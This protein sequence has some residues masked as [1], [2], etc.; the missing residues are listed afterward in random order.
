MPL[1][2]IELISFFMATELLR[3]FHQPPEKL[4]WLSG[5]SA[6]FGE[7]P[8][9][10]PRDFPVGNYGTW[11]KTSLGDNLLTQEGGLFDTAT[12]QLVPGERPTYTT[13]PSTERARADRA[14]A[15]VGV[16]NACNNNNSRYS[17]DLL[18][19]GSEQVHAR[20]LEELQNGSYAALIPFAVEPNTIGPAIQYAAGRIPEDNV[21][22]VDAGVDPSSTQAAQRASETTGVNVVNQQEVL[23]CIDWRALKD[24]GILPPHLLT[25]PKGNKGLTIYAGLLALEAAGKLDKTVML[26]DSDILN[27]GQRG[28]E[29]QGSYRE[30]YSPL[31]YLVL[32]YVYPLSDIPANAVMALR[33]GQG[34]YNEPLI[35]TANSIVNGNFSEHVR[36]LA[37]AYATLGWPI[38]GERAIRGNLLRAMPLPTGIFG[39][40]SHINVAL[41]SKDVQTGHKGV[42]QV[43]IPNQKRENRPSPRDREYSIVFGASTYLERLLAFIEQVGRDPLEWTLNDTAAFNQLYGGRLD[44]QFVPNRYEQQPNAPIYLASDF[45]LPSMVQLHQLG[46]VDWDRMQNAIVKGRK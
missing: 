39:L 14:L 7:H 19:P 40:E 2:E 13:T 24:L 32:P 23:A 41:S 22:T 38:T 1:R 45:V 43:A 4:P 12:P 36:A 9:F 37:L 46:V 28:N 6:F 42:M 29:H 15:H 33:T 26:H 16:Y 25:P 8:D 10:I 18:S 11:I 35:R 20:V 3:T 44:R 21:F 34:R 27:L 17:I 5:E 30:F 31:E